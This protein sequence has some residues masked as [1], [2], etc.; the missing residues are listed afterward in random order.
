VLNNIVLGENNYDKDRLD[1]AIARSGLQETLHKF[2]FGLDTIVTEN[3]KNISGG[4]RQRIAIARALYKNAG[5]IIMDEPFNGLDEGSSDN[6]LRH[7]ITHNRQAISYCDKILYLNEQQTQNI[8]NTY[9]GIP[10]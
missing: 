5:L 8:H 4:Q 7:L 2:P 3:G 1:A 9:S 10:G 6:I